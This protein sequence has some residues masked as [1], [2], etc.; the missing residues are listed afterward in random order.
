MRSLASLCAAL[1]VVSLGVVGCKKEQPPAAAV[2]EPP[3]AKREP[4]RAVLPTDPR[5]LMATLQR[6]ARERVEGAARV[7]T[8][9]DVLKKGGVALAGLKQVLAAT[10]QARYCVAGHTPEGRAVAV[11]EYESADAAQKGR[12]YSLTSFKSATNRKILVKDNLTLTLSGGAGEVQDAQDVKRLT[13]LFE[14]LTIPLP[15]QTPPQSP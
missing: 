13:A 12:R 3:I 7:E 14:G 5:A 11:C 8:V 10:V 15:E 4:A 2:A 9:V 1:L 6:E